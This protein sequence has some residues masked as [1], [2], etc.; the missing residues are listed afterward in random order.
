M[1]DIKFRGQRVNTKEWIY[2]YLYRISET[3]NPF[4]MEKDSHGRSY[5]VISETVGQFTG[6]KDKNGV[7]IYEGDIIQFKHIRAKIVFHECS[8]CYEWIDG[9]TDKLR[10]QKIEEMFWNT[11]LLF[12]VVGSVYENSKLLEVESES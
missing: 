9:R 4:I 6:F 5:E 7:D 8:F 10:C 1:R 2:G 11:N 3:L 12:E